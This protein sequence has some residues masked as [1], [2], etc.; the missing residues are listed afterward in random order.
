MKF[1]LKSFVFL[2]ELSLFLAFLAI[3]TSHEGFSMKM[4]QVSLISLLIAAILYLTILKD[5]KN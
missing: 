1:L 4:L 2:G 5:E 3:L